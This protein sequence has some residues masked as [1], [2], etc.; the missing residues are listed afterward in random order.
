MD[1]Y[2]FQDGPTFPLTEEDTDWGD[3]LDDAS[4][5]SEDSDEDGYLVQRVSN[6]IEWNEDDFKDIEVP[7]TII[8]DE[9]PWFFQCSEA[10]WEHKCPYS[11]G[12]HQ[13]VKNI[14][15]IIE[16]PQINIIAEEHQEAIKEAARSAIMAVINKLDQESKERLKKQEF[17]VYRRKKLNQLTTNQTKNPPLDV[18][19]PKTSNIER[20]K[21]NFDLEGALSKMFV[22]IPLREVIKVPSVKERFDN[23][24]QGSDGPLKHGTIGHI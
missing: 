21:L 9:N 23:F 13:Q 3:Y 12:F 20:V 5:I 24:F 11:N 17:Q 2:L 18:I 15:H 1:P 10:H 16:G 19:F 7:S 14:G 4:N 8:V 6:I 22:T